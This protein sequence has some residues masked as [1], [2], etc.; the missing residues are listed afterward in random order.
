MSDSGI[1]NRTVTTSE[2]DW[3]DED[4]PA[5]KE[6]FRFDGCTYGC[7]SEGG[8][9]VSDKPGDEFS[10]EVPSDAVTWAN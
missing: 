5:G 3:L 10:Y 9:A 8:V 4:L 2:C 7:I 1:L 6:V